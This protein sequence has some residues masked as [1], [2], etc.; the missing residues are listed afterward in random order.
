MTNQTSQS[1]VKGALILTLAGLV[2][3]ILSAGYRVPLQNITGD[4]G[5]YIYQ[6]VYPILGMALILSLYGFPAAISKLVSE[7][8]EEK[9]FLSF[10]SFYLPVFGW[11]MGICGLIFVIGFTQAPG[12]AAVMGDEKLI[13]SLRSAFFVFLLVPFVSLFR[14]VFQGMNQMKPTA[15]S[16]VV[17]QLIRVSVIIVTAV[18]VV[19]F[20]H[21]Y[22]VGIGAS[23]ASF[24][25]ACGGLGV[26]L[27][28]VKRQSIWKNKRWNS[29]VSYIQT[30][31]FYGLFICLNYTLLLSLQLV[32]SF[33]LVPGLL[34]AGEG[35]EAARVLK[36]VFDRGQPLIQLG[37]VL[38]SSIALALIPS[39]TRKRFE[40]DPDE[41]KKYMYTS[42]KVS[43]LIALGATAG[44]IVLFPEINQLFFQNTEGTSALRI[45][46]IVIVFASVSLTTSS[47]LQGLGYIR[48]TAVLILIAIGLKAIGN[49]WLIPHLELHGAAV[50]SIMA[51]TF[52]LGGNVVLLGKEFPLNE[53]MTMPW[54]SITGALTGM[55][56]LLISFRGLGEKVMTYGRVSLLVYTLS[57]T[58]FG[59]IVYFLLLLILGAFTRKELEPMPFYNT[60]QRLLPKGLK[61]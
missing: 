20:D 48:H 12:I 42:T 35:L 21:M 49:Y 45:L 24:L 38:A 30:I 47:V 10:P 7:L 13:P 40:K 34:K 5:F 52:V 37:T 29:S 56:L 4:L 51:V 17:D 54:L 33:S 8:R 31:L 2:S 43:L 1:V 16:Q 57:L 22:A 15:V 55:I 41:V 50:A 19:K 36:G 39:V 59:A 25:G 53:W 46:M 26:L 3:K 44:L 27:F 14:G 18:L 61:P 6:Q 60:L 9:E 23:V 58:A 32:D 28:F 11:L